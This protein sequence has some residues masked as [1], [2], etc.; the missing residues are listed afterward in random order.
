MTLAQLEEIV[1]KCSFPGM[2]LRAEKIGALLVIYGQYDEA[3]TVT[4]KVERQ[5]TRAWLIEPGATVG[6]VV[7]TCF[8]LCLTSM[9]HRT[10]ESFAYRDEAIYHPHH[11][12]DVLVALCEQEKGLRDA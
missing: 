5:T 10:R 6:Q 2:T 7:G 3:D 8:R 1:S 12:P 11:D 4:H 9:E